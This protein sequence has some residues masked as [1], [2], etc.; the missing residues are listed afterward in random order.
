MDWADG[1]CLVVGCLFQKCAEGDELCLL[2]LFR[3][4]GSVANP[5]NL[6]GRVLDETR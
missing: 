6:F 1:A 3:V 2:D 5:K 4:A